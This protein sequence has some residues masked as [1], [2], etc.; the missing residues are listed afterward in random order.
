MGQAFSEL[1]YLQNGGGLLGAGGE[2]E[3]VA[4]KLALGGGGEVG[5]E[6]GT[7]GFRSGLAGRR[8]WKTGCA[9]RAMGSLS[10]LDAGTQGSTR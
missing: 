2:G 3:G 7:P 8:F 4:E 5:V 1:S 10:G 9:K 6:L